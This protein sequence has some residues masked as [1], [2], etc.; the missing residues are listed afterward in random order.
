MIR[1]YMHVRPRTGC[2]YG[3]PPHGNRLFTAYRWGEGGVFSALCFALLIISTSDLRASAFACGGA[4][5][6]AGA[7]ASQVYQGF[8][9]TDWQE[10]MSTRSPTL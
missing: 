6:G 9:R 1:T 3:N 2:W 8:I 5:A 10:S 4:G 7:G